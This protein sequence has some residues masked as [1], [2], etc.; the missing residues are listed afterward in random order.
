MGKG[1]GA[2][3]SL[4]EGVGGGESFTHPEGRSQSLTSDPALK[5]GNLGEGEGDV[6]EQGERQRSSGNKE[7]TQEARRITHLH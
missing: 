1:K 2:G 6:S 4:M 3:S 5:E 7:S